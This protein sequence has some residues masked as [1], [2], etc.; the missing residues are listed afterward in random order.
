MIRR[1][2]GTT[3]IELL[4]AV[5]LGSILVGS[6]VSLIVVG[7]Q[8]YESAKRSL[9]DTTAITEVRA[10][11]TDDVRSA[12]ASLSAVSL[13][14]LTLTLVILDQSSQNAGRRTIVYQ[15]VPCPPDPTTCLNGTLTRT[16]TIGTNAALG[17]Q[18]LARTLAK[19]YGSAV[20]SLS[21]GTVIATVPLP[22][23]PVQTV[24][25]KAAMRVQAP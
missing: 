19:S 16:V 2:E 3:L 18:T 10:S 12:V 4:A 13:D 6:L 25:I 24:E 11:L 8:S 9:A 1:E 23:T 14:G 21:S 15:Y 20:F 17:T 7:F 5:V 22:T